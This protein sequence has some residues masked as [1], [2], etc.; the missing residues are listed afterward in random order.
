MSYKII[1][2]KIFLNVLQIAHDIVI[3][4]LILKKGHIF[5]TLNPKFV[6]E[7]TQTACSLIIKYSAFMSYFIFI[8]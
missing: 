4:L 1:I 2:Y 8:L 5:T 7:K 6:F 3:V